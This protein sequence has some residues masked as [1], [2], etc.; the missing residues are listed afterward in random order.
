VTVVGIGGTF[1]RRTGEALLNTITDLDWG[2][3]HRCL[4][5][6]VCLNIGVLAEVCL[7]DTGY[8]FR[9]SDI[10]LILRLQWKWDSEALMHGI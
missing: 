5:D 8:S 1:D 7:L 3:D 10:A 9:A 2:V 6:L 4:E